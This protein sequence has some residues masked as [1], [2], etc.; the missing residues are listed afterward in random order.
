L[1]T[2]EKPIQPKWIK[3]FLNNLLG[4]VPFGQTVELIELTC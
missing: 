3:A 2:G 4:L 1:K